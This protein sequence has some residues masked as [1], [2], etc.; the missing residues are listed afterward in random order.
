MSYKYSVKIYDDWL[1]P[2][3]GAPCSSRMAALDVGCGP[4]LDTHFL[5]THGFDVYACDISSQAL[6]ESQKLNPAVSHKIADAVD[7]APFGDSQF[8]LV[9]AGLSLHYFDRENT[10]RAFL[11]V[12]RVLKPNGLFLFRLN[13]WDDFEFGAPLEFSD[14]RLIEYPDGSKKQFF[15]ESMIR[16]VIA[17]SFDVVSLEK[18]I[19]GRYGKPKSFYEVC[20]RKSPN[21]THTENVGYAAVS[22]LRR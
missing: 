21:Q 13:A 4:G 16:E 5:V 9:V 2:W 11:S 12:N 3:L 22:N 10:S 19:S 18:K 1:E 14:W 20:A 17:G 8:D 6:V 7:L 15:T